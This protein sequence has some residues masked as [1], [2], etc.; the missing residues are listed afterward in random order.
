MRLAHF[1]RE[2]LDAGP[3]VA[4]PGIFGPI[5]PMPEAHHR[6]LVGALCLDVLGSFR[7]IA[8]FLRHS[9]HVFGCSAMRRSGERRHCSGDR[10]VKVGIRPRHD[11]RGER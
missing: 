4:C 7:R 8:N 1:A 10:A 11:A 6:L 2:L 3:H 5:D 9:H